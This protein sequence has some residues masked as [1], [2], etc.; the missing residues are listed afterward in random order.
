MVYKN[1]N[2][3]YLF[4]GVYKNS[5]EASINL[6]NNSFFNLNF[7]KKNQIK[8][9]KLC[10][11][12]FLKKKIIPAF[13]K[14]HTQYLINSISILNKK[15]VSVLDVGG[16]WGIGHLHCLESFSKKI[17]NKL[18][19]HIYD[20]KKICELG[21]MFY[22][23]K[24]NTNNLFYSNKLDELLTKKFDIIFFGSS[25][26]YF[27][28]PVD[29]LK[30]VIC[31]NFKYLIFIDVYL[32]NQK[33]F[34]TLQNYYGAFT[35]HSFIN[36]FDFFRI[37]EKKTRLISI[38]NSHTVRLGKIDKLN[39]NNFPKKLRLKNSFNIILEKK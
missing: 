24:M 17:F 33:T 10:N 37:L 27:D 1:S 29:L 16:G 26:Q 31:C 34:F 30:R 39:M 13:Y 2:F 9:I 15:N 18:K 32:T 6:K 14:Q 36:K 3:Q 28:Q 7:Y 5:E 21:E 20:L 11:Q 35:S 8:I 22:K 38:T 25:L 19:Y 4:D 23:K 12:N